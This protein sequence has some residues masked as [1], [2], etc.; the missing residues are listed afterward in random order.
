MKP[1]RRQRKAINEAKRAGYNAGY[2]EGYKKGLHD[3]N[4]FITLAESLSKVL[5]T[6]A[7]QMN[8]SEFVKMC[9]E[10]KRLEDEWVPITMRKLTPEEKKGN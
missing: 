6:V 4:P 3:G 10:A 1:N 7:D 9:I 5:N 8:D 2:A